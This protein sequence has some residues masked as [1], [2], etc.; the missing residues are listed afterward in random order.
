MY[1]S[2]EVLWI[3][4]GREWGKKGENGVKRGKMGENGVKR[5]KMG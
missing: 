2:V 4:R 1:E 3:E 5:G